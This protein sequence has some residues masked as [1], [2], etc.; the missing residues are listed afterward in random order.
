M[1]SFISIRN[2]LGFKNIFIQANKTL[3]II[4]NEVFINKNKIIKNFGKISFIGGSLA[5]LLLKN[6]VSCSNDDNLS[7]LDPKEDPVEKFINYAFP[8]VAPLGFGG[9]MG[10]ITGLALRKL[11]EKAAYVLG[12]SFVALQGLSYTG[13]IKIDFGKIKEDSEK[14]IDAD[15]DGKITANDFIVIWRKTKSFLIYNLPSASGFS[16]G[17]AAGFYLG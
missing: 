15:N 2:R 8:I 4:K 6:D 5:Y 9:V 16:A 3:K 1:A 12:L 11:G 10:F 13:Y 17:F 14:F 7:P